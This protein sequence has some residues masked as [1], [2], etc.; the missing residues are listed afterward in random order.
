[1]DD[2]QF[3][4]TN[5]TT[6]GKARQGKMATDMAVTRSTIIIILDFNMQY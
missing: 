3:L 2:R 6:K 5:R 4:L 1:M